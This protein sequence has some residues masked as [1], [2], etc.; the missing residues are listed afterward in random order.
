MPIALQIKLKDN[1][2]FIRMS[3]GLKRQINILE[4]VPRKTPDL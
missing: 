2:P 1:K 3:T 4:R